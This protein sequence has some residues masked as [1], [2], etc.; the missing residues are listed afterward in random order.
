ME[1]E[2]HV[3]QGTQLPSSLILGFGLGP[4]GGRHR[5]AK[6]PNK[7]MT[8]DEVRQLDLVHHVG[9]KMKHEPSLKMYIPRNKPEKP[10]K[11]PKRIRTKHVAHI[12]H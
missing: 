3:E 9:F 12:F 1:H 10:A 4:S 7:R 8:L 6:W 5:P 11:T 2:S